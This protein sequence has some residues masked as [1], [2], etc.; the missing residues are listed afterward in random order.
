MVGLALLVGIVFWIGEHRQL[1]KRAAWRQ[2]QWEKA[3]RPKVLLS[4]QGP[5]V[6]K[7]AT[8]GAATIP[9]KEEPER[10]REPP[11]AEP[12]SNRGVP[13][14]PAGGVGVEGEPAAVAEPE[15]VPVEAEAPPVDQVVYL[16]PDL[17]KIELERVMI[18]WEMMPES[19]EF[20]RRPGL[21]S[22]W[23]SSDGTTI[24][25]FERQSGYPYLEIRGPMADDLAEFLPDDLPVHLAA[26]KDPTI[27]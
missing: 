25:F 9:S 4:R 22:R 2:Q 19:D 10:G 20:P 11:V 15:P 8:T 5:G 24:D 18:T 3:E 21:Q 14:A 6:E 17:D 23:R 1:S 27:N 16:D 13:V 26:S 7:E 12:E